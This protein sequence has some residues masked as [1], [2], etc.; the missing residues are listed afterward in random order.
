[1]LLSELLKNVSYE[2]LNGNLQKNIEH[3]TID[4]RDIVKDS[5]FICI[6]GL[7]VDSHKFICDTISKGATVV[8]VSQD[9][10]ITD[11]KV[12]YIK[13]S[14]TRLAMSYIASN[15]YNNPEKKLKI[16]GITGTNGKTSTTFFMKHVLRT[17]GKNVGIIGTVNTMI[18][19]DVIDVP[20]K[21]STTP[22]SLELMKILDIMSKKCEY[23]VME[24]SSHALELKKL[25]GIFFE[26]A[27]FS[28][29]TQDHLDL[30][31]TMDN[32]FNAKAK[33]FKQSKQACVNIDDS[34]GQK[35]IDNCTCKVITYGINKKSD[36]F[37]TNIKYDA[38]TIKYTVKTD[39]KVTEIFINIPGKFTVYNSLSVIASS[40]CLGIPIEVIKKSFESMKGVPGRIE[41]VPNDKQFNVFIDYSHTPD[42][43]LNIIS[44]IRQFT[45]GRVI[46]IFGCGGDRDKEKRPI[47]GKI[48]GELSD[49]SII[50]SDNPRSEQSETIIAQIEEGIKNTKGDYFKIIDRK[51]AII[52]AIKLAKK[53]DSVII[54]GK[55]HEN[56][57][58]FKDKTIHFDDFEE[59]KNALE[60]LI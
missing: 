11:H 48:S 20:F 17:Y 43:L 10:L 22:D 1:M 18:N 26:V 34:Y 40:L 16:I 60:I 35:L 38:N 14:D 12:T 45:K 42:G 28:N 15:F 7:K 57:Q 6:V 32:Y 8:L 36:L 19:E 44:S 52:H 54:A 33:L 53:D 58:I 55:G 25:E 5:L 29:L 2:M 51:E 31:L 39:D 47:M 59:A 24:V 41:S 37:V 50:T 9:V 56:Y 30:H 46:T 4:S 49:I 27:I 13:V 23:V 21:T 3:I